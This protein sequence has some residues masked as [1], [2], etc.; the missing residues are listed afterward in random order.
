MDGIT[1][2]TGASA[3]NDIGYQGQTP[4]AE[5]ALAG[6]MVMTRA[7]LVVVGGTAH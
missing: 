3:L 7:A 4:S 2:A 6:A 5:Y 1:K